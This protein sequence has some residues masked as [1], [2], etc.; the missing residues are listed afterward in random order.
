MNSAS[1]TFPVSI[2]NCGQLF[3]FQALS[4]TIGTHHGKEQFLDQTI[5]PSGYLNC[6]LNEMEPIIKMWTYPGESIQNRVVWSSTSCG[7]FGMLVITRR[8]LR[9]DE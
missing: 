9:M 2:E 6:Y 5:T 7:G 1:N 3:S 8:V 4:L